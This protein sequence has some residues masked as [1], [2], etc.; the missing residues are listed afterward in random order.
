M[1]DLLSQLVPRQVKCHLKINDEELF[2]E[3][4]SETAVK[5]RSKGKALD[6]CKYR[7]NNTIYTDEESFR[8]LELEKLT[9]NVSINKDSYGRKALYVYTSVPTFDSGDREWDSAINE[10]LMFDGRDIN[11]VKC[12]RGYRI[13]SITIYGK[14]ISASENTRPWLERLGFPQDGVTFTD[15]P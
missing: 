13:A 1:F 12:R 15:T 6:G 5:H 9:E 2:L 8:K 14:L 7:L 10:Y 4:R 11:L 3:F